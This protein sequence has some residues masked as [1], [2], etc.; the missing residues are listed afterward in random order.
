MAFV[1]LLQQLLPDTLVFLEVQQKAYLTD[2]SVTAILA[3]GWIFT[4]TVFILTPFSW[5]CRA[6]T[7]TQSAVT[8][9]NKSSPKTPSG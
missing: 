3:L 2:R 6:C 5:I 7:A 9:T 4:E 1:F 8:I